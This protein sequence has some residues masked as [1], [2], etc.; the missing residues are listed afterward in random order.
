MDP[1]RQQ[2]FPPLAGMVTARVV[3][4]PPPP[5]AA[6]GQ[7]DDIAASE[8]RYAVED[9]VSALHTVR[10]KRRKNAN[11]NRAAMKQVRVAAADEEQANAT[12]AISKSL[13][14]K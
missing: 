10:S 11:N 14:R 3:A 12:I 5:D 9:V 7:H 2:E 6:D 1:N 4:R 8:A 13:G